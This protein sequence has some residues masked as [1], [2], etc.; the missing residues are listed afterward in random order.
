LTEKPSLR[1]TAYGVPRLQT[2]RTIGLLGG[3][4]NPAHQGHLHITLYALK[5][6]GLDEVWWLVTPKNPLKSEA[7]LAAYEK[8]LE[9]AHAVAAAHPRIRV[10]DI[11]SQAHTH[12]SYEIIALLKRK[13]AGAHFVWLMGADNLAQFHRWRRQREIMAE[14]PIV[15]FDRAP[16]SHTAIRSKTYVQMRK[17]L[18]KN[19][20]VNGLWAAPALHFVH[21]RRD[22]LSSTQ[23]RKTLGKGAFLM[24]NENK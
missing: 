9:S 20:Q 19:T 11:E 7:C 14:I 5:K 13:Y 3:S 15:V 6:L 16:Y 12:Y 2:H 24:H 4:F 8:R 17:F 18:L 23:L 22:P 21:L 10:L 1:H